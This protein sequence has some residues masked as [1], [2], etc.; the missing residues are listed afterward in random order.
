MPVPSAI[1]VVD[2]LTIPLAVKRLQESKFHSKVLA[3]SQKLV[4]QGKFGSC[5]KWIVLA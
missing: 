1:S 2:L 4:D 5:M 3:L